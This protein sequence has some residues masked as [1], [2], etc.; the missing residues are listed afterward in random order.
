M[1]KIYGTSEFTKEQEEQIDKVIDATA[2][3]LDVLLIKPEYIK[4][5]ELKGVDARW[6]PIVPSEIADLVADY[7]CTRYS[8]N[9]FYP[10]H[11]ENEDGKYVNDVMN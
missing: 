2:N 9:V 3:L 10:I 11:V 8:V 1:A 5:P 6:C 7:I 4:D